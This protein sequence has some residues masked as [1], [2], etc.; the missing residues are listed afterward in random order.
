MFYLTLQE[1]DSI[2]PNKNIFAVDI[3]G[4]SGSRSTDPKDIAQEVKAVFE[5]SLGKE[6]AE[7][8]TKGITQETANKT[9]SPTQSTSRNQ[10][11]TQSNF[12]PV[13]ADD[14]FLRGFNSDDTDGQLT[15]STYTPEQTATQSIRPPTWDDNR[16]KL[17]HKG[18]SETT[19]Y[20]LEGFNKGYE[21]KQEQTILPSKRGSPNPELSGYT[22]AWE[23]VQQDTAGSGFQI[24]AREDSQPQT[25]EEFLKAYEDGKTYYDA[26]YEEMARYEFESNDSH[27]MNS[28]WY[29]ALSREESRV[30]EQLSAI[31]EQYPSL[32][33][34]VELKKYLTKINDDDFL[35]QS[36]ASFDVGQLTELTNAAYSQY[37]TDPTADN[38][39]YADYLNS[40]LKTYIENNTAA[41]NSEDA[42][43]P[44]FSQTAAGYLPQLGH[45][46]E[47]GVGYGIVGAGGGAA[48]GSVVPVV[49][50]PVVQ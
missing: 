43:F 49:V 25:Y 44:L 46:L 17:S 29:D 48:V 1:G 7:L 40:V 38:K 26:I 16:K 41:L 2:R 20:F 6:D 13:N 27:F 4:V 37:L 11:T 42:I 12:T 23:P 34:A 21:D 18:I 5:A 14:D 30:R 39:A 47:S 31:Q 3:S 8:V 28:Q 45:Q 24:R 50:Q 35:G 32:E 10:S 19:D 22:G 36:A 9:A 33:Q 15:S